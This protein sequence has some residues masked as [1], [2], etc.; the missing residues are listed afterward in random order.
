MFPS[1]VTLNVDLI[2]ELY[3][4]FLDKTGLF[5]GPRLGSKTFLGFTH[6]Y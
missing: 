4:T 5:L 1:I 3:G 6:M 2:L